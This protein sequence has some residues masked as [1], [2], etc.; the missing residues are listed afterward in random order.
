M[1]LNVESGVDTM[2]GCSRRLTSS[3]LQIKRKDC[4]SVIFR[5]FQDAHTPDSV[6]DPFR[7]PK[8][9]KVYLGEV[10]D[11]MNVLCPLP[12][13]APVGL[14]HLWTGLCVLPLVQR[15]G[16]EDDER[17]LSI[18][19]LGDSG[20]RGSELQVRPWVFQNA[21]CLCSADARCHQC[22]RFGLS[23]HVQA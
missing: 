1:F 7:F 13:R 12:S 2:A 8:A 14:M 17:A 4:I 11:G 18:V 19:S 10:W 23:L 15:V 21:C 6:P 3:P 22:P 20:G 5:L 16:N 9:N